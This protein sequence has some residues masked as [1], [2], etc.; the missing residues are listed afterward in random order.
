MSAIQKRPSRIAVLISGFGSNLQAIIDKVRSGYIPCA[1]VVVVVS[2]RKD[3]Y[4][5]ERA[6]RAGIP[7]VYFPLKPFKDA[8]K[9]RVEYDAALAD[10]VAAY[11]PDWVVLAGWMHV[12]SMGFLQHFPGRVVNLHPALP[13][14]FPGTHAIQRAYEAYQRGEIDRTGCMVHLVPDAGVD[15]GPPVLTREVP[16]YPSDSLED[17]EERMHATEHEILPEALRLLI[18][19][20]C[21]KQA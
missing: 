18:L 13:G 15:V 16:I 2:N 19:R 7:T 6:E 10:V 17:L 3:A 14:Q 21:E 4:G 5:L 20:D 9:P 11:E 1:E 12:L 8:G